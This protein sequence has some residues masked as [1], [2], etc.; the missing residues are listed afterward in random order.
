VEIPLLTIP[1][2]PGRNVPILI[3]TAAINFRLNKLGYNTAK[4]FNRELMHRI[5]EGK[6]A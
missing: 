4:E 3:E 1:V 6:K 2:K 5:Q